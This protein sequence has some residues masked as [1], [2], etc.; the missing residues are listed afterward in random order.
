[1]ATH[2]FDDL[3]RRLRAGEVLHNLHLSDD[4]FELLMEADQRVTGSR[5]PTWNG[6]E[7]K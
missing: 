2:D 6:K 5:G 1:M 3:A 7:M 4:E